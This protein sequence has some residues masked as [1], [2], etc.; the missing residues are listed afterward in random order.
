M[1]ANPAPES[2][3]PKFSINKISLYNRL[4][5][6]LRHGVEFLATIQTGATEH[7]IYRHIG[8]EQDERHMPQNVC[9]LVDA[10]QSIV[11]LRPC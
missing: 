5:C 1:V 8:R 7:M 3:H 6:E 2:S 11:L 4:H 9:G 10:A